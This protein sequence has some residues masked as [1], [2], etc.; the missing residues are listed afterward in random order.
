MLIDRTSNS[1]VSNHER[2]YSDNNSCLRKSVWETLPLP[3]VVYGEDQLWA[4]EILRNGYKKAYASTAVVRHSHEYG[5]RET[6]IRANTEWH[7]YNQL[8]WRKSALHQR[9]GFADGRTSLYQRPRS[10]V[11]CTQISVMTI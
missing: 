7:F 2:F 3:D 1:I 5:F 6:V 8:H 9:A 11:N 10:S 4:R